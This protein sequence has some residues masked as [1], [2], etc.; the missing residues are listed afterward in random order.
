MDW[1]KKVKPGSKQASRKG[2]IKRF[3]TYDAT[4]TE[5]M[6]EFWYILGEMILVIS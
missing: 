4:T 2:D 6:I 3:T 1:P 5:N